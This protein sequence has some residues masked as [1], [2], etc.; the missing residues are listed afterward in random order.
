MS[1][2]L[3]PAQSRLLATI[4]ADGYSEIPG[5]GQRD[6]GR[7]RSHWW[8]TVNSLAEHGLVKVERLGSGD[9]WRA[10]RAS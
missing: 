5:C 8:R 9:I 7:W 1:R 2:G 6:S 3:S 10:R 4:D